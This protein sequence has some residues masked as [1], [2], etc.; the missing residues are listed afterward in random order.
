M[1]KLLLTLIVSSV[2]VYAFALTSITTKKVNGTPFCGGA[3]VSVSFTVDAPANAGN[4]FTAQLSAKNGSFTT[5][6]NIGTLTS[7]GSGTISATIPLGTVTGS[8]Y[9]IRVVASNPAVIGAPCP[10]ALKINPAP[11]AVATSGITACAAT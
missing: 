2:C 3:A 1:K 8:K 5:P 11:T 9:K 10:N 7:T 6:V 4:V